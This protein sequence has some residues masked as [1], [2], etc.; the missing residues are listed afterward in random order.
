VKK[1]VFLALVSSM[2]EEAVLNI[3]T[4]TGPRGPRGFRGESG[5]DFSIEDAIP[6]IHQA[7]EDN[8][9]SLKLKFSDLSEEDKSSLVGPRGKDGRHGVDG[10]DASLEDISEVVLSHKESLKLKFSDLSEEDKSSLVGPRGKDGRHGKSIDF[11]ECL[12]SLKTYLYSYVESN[13]DRLKL[14]FNDLSEEDIESIRG[15]QGARGYRGEKGED[16]KDFDWEEYRPEILQKISK[17]VEENKLTFSKLTPEERDS[18]KLHF[19]DLTFE[20]RKLLKGPRGQRG[21]QGIQGEVGPKGEKGDRG[22]IGPR[23]IPGVQGIR[24][25]SG[26]DGKDGKDGEDASEI[27]KVSIQSTEKDMYFVFEFSD[28]TILRTNKVDLPSII[29]TYYA[30]GGG[31]NGNGGSG[32]DGKSAYEVAVDEG[33]IGTE[34]EWLDSLV[35]EDGIDGKSAYEVAVDEGF[36]GTEQEWLDSLVGQDGI[37]GKSAYEVAVDEGFIGTEQ[38]WLDSLVGQDGIDGK[39]AYEVAVDEGFIGTEQEW[40]DSLVGPQGPPGVGTMDV[41]NE[42]QDVVFQPTVINFAE[43]VEAY[44]PTMMSD[45]QFLEDVEPSIG[46]YSVGDIV[47]VRIKGRDVLYDFPIESNAVVGDVVRISGNVAVRA[48]ADTSLNAR[49]I[50]IVEKTLYGFSNIRIS[51]ISDEVY[52]GLNPSID[53]YLSDTEAGKLVTTPPSIEVKIGVPVSSTRLVIKI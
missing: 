3:E 52:S 50:G 33:F 48:I 16:G 37:D 24:G 17:L 34:Q 15:P 21:K 5:K 12:E 7:I 8:R 1:E 11:E 27:T 29:H 47:A 2:I 4:L 31:G 18:L 10:K 9:E 23:G 22:N 39:S 6:I 49:A 13:L 20:E 46:L 51:G 42:M 26:V 45:W 44:N 53:Y 36:I 25:I 19:E 28:G 40:L 35:G 38:E 43:G 41:L 14:K 30:M 32:Q